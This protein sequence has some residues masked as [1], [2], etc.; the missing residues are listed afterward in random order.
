M[1]PSLSYTV[2]GVTGFNVL[3]TITLDSST[4]S[5]N[6]ELVILVCTV[7][8]G[9]GCLNFSTEILLIAEE[10]ECVSPR[11]LEDVGNIKSLCGF[12]FLLKI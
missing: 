10:S 12:M 5:Y 8:Q 3:D 11:G 7:A 9:W 2:L 4:Q 1:D 6:L